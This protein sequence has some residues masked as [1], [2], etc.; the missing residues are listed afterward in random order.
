MGDDRNSKNWNTGLTKLKTINSLIFIQ[1]S[2]SGEVS[3]EVDRLRRI[4]DKMYEEI[5][6]EDDEYTLVTRVGDT[7]SGITVTEL[8][9]RYPL[10]QVNNGF[11]PT[12]PGLARFI[13]HIYN[14][15]KNIYEVMHIR[16]ELFQQHTTILAKRPPYTISQ[17]RNILPDEY[18]KV[19]ELVDKYGT[20]ELKSK[21]SNQKN[22]INCILI[23]LGNYGLDLFMAASQYGTLLNNFINKNKPLFLDRDIFKTLAAA[24]AADLKENRYYTATVTLVKARF[25]VKDKWLV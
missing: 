8:I 20:E 10:Y 9:T 19:A 25:S 5:G 7:L 3:L 22:D 12:E 13:F 1:I 23:T 15:K 14:S 11:V 2:K 6:I 17:Y 4:I 21:F 18:N 16:A 24:E